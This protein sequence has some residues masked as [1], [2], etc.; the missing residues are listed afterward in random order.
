MFPITG[1]FY[2]GYTDFG[3]CHAYSVLFFVPPI[4]FFL[5]TWQ[6]SLALIMVPTGWKAEGRLFSSIQETLE[7]LS[8]VIASHWE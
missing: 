4:I 7:K 2:R 8:Y 3:L 5:T 6:F 1:K